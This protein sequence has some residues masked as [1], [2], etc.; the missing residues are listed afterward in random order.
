VTL[1]PRESLAA[2]EDGG[3]GIARLRSAADALA[4]TLPTAAPEQLRKY[5]SALERW[6]TVHNLTSIDGEAASLVGHVLDSLAIVAPLVRHSMGRALTVLDVGTG[7]GF[8]AAV[9][10]IARPDWTVTAIDSVGKKVA[11]IRQAVGEAGILNLRPY[12]SRA[13]DFRAG[14]FDVLVSRAFSSLK[15]FAEKT[16][17]LRASDGVWVA[18]KGRY[19]MDEIAELPPQVE[20]FHVEPVKVPGLQAERCLIW[21]RG[22]TE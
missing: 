13:E 21:M 7:A 12:H 14:P 11:F 10:A 5:V 18:Q 6:N 22:H 17:H 9:L 15:K 2:T 8:P 3:L 4:L 1:S 20:V 19:P 16:E